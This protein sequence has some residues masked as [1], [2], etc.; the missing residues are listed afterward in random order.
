[1]K[2]G[3]VSAAAL[4]LGACGGETTLPPQ[5]QILLY[6]DTDAPLA[7]AP[8]SA[9][10]QQLPPPLFDRLRIEVRD[11]AAP[12][13][14]PPLARRDFPLHRGYFE[15]GPESVGIVPELGTAPLQARARLYRSTNVRAGEIA[16]SSTVD[17]T[18]DL[19]PVPAEG[20]LKVLMELWVDDAGM[21]RVLPRARPL[22]ATPRESAVG[23][24]R[25][26]I[27]R[28]CAE[29][30]GAG[31]LCVPG[32]AFWMGDPALRDDSEVADADRERLVVVSPFFMDV[33]EVTVAELRDHAEDILQA[34]AELPP[35]WSGSSDG[36][37]E[38]DY[39]TYTPGPSTN[40][41]AD[42]QGTLPVN[43]V[44]WSA[45]RAY[46]HAVGKE[47]PSEAM[48]EFLASGR[49]LEQEYVW[50]NDEPQWCDDSVVAARAGF[51]A[52]ASFDGA[53][54]PAGT[55]GGPLP[56]GGGKR[57]R[58]ELEGGEVLDLAGNLSE[59][60]LDFFNT[61]E[62]GVW[63][64]SGVLTD[65]VALEPGAAGDRRTLRGGSWRSRYVQ[66]RAAARLGRDPEAVNR[67]VG[68]RCARRP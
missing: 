7:R 32:G 4:A 38:D 20:L 2:S 49:G 27:P 16:V 17:V 22:D 25:G 46:C 33:H 59:W 12:E 14:S 54:R 45:A 30:P 1:M 64:A 40:D 47:L 63:A 39:S 35:Q 66:L 57:D 15:R 62:E 42:E 36:S 37:S 67:A 60:T 23:T 13:G 68:F 44:S 51:G 50:G 31:E 19:P 56:M 28:P 6:I 18:Q 9:P 53:C 41:E 48:F 26:A 65:P 58:A 21:P 29:P 52:Y 3:L 5:G 8:G 24:W 55:I 10:D 61:A 11:A 43:G 34:G